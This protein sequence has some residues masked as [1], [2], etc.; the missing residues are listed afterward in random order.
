MPRP[1]VLVVVG[2]R[3]DAIKMLPVH[4]RLRMDGR[5]RVGLLSTGQ[6]DGVLRE[7]LRMYPDLPDYDLELMRAGQTLARLAS[8]ACP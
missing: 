5:V 4:R 6:H 8:L 3:P 1:R 2:T 7:V